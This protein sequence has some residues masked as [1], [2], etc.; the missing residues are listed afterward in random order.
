VVTERS[1]FRFRLYPTLEQAGAL[2]RWAGCARVVWNAALEQ[3]RTAARMGQ[4]ASWAAQDAELAELK[5]AFPWLSEPHSDVCQQLLRDL[6]RAHRNWWA[7]RARRPRF[8]RK[9]RDSVRIQSRPGKGEIQIRRLNRRWGEV[10][11]PKLGWVRFRWSRKPVGEIKHLTIS[12][13]ALGWHVSLCCERERERPAAYL[14]PAVGLDRGV[15]VA[16]A[17]S[18]GPTSCHA[19]R[20]ARRSACA[21]WLAGLAAR[22]PREGSAR[23][24]SVAARAAISARSTGLPSCGSARRASAETSF[25][26]SRP[27]SPRA[28]AWL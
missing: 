28:T 17:D 1:G 11:V 12:R 9:G 5:R 14:G 6:D 16:V 25:I 27:R 22:R 18:D 7:G 24:A 10:R 8:K 26:A 2:A 13:D 19:C 15:A 21:G 3:R 23:R 4:R 20:A